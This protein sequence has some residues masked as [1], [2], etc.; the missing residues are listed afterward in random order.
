MY[1]MNDMLEMGLEDGEE[2]PSDHHRDIAAFVCLC[3]PRIN[4]RD[5][6]MENVSIVNKI[7]AEK[8][9]KITPL[10]LTELGCILN[11]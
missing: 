3:N 4:T 9:K 7:P 5:L 11:I 10:D 6:L 8:I 2:W 1:I